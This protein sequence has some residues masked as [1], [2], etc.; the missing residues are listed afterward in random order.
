MIFDSS[1]YQSDIPDDPGGGTVDWTNPWGEYKYVDDI[2]TR[3]DGGTP[4]FLQAIRAALAMKLKEQMGVIEMMQREEEL[5]DRMMKGL[6]QTEG[7]RILAGNIHHRLGIIS[8]YHP[9]I[10]FNLIVKMLSDRFGIQVR[11]RCCMC[12]H[13]RTLSPGSEL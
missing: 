4:G 5:V 11:R 3:E 9:D 6:Q 12:R 8:F 13:I 7:I 1:I 2:E 10:H